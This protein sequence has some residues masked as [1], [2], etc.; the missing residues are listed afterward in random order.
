M[1]NCTSCGEALGCVD[2]SLADNTLISEKIQKAADGFVQGRD[3]AS[4]LADT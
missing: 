3:A 4:K 1:T 2:H